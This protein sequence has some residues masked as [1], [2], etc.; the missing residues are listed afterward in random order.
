MRRELRDFPDTNTFAFK[1]L[2]TGP[3]RRWSK[4]QMC[5]FRSS[6][7]S[8]RVGDPESA[9]PQIWLIL[10]TPREPAS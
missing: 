5:A 9:V 1:G 3:S 10:T 7:S 4:G 8:K 6:T 2:T